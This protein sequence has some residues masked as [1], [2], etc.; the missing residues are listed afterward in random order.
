MG[1]IVSLIVGFFVIVA[2]ILAVLIPFFI[3]KIR[4]EVVS[5]NLKLDKLV[6]LLENRGIPVFKAQIQSVDT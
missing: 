4:N 5:M 6:D 3:L 2:A 1:D